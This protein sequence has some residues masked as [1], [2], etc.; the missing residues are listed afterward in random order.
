MR[1]YYQRTA[2]QLKVAINQL[3]QIAQNNDLAGL[4]TF[5]VDLKT[6]LPE[7]IS[8]ENSPILLDGLRV[9]SVETMPAYIDNLRDRL[10][11]LYNDYRSRSK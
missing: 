8:Y 1:A 3:D 11:N 10:C 2:K 7:R 4:H 5:V 9:T 6:S